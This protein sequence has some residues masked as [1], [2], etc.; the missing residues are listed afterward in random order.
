MYPRSASVFGGSATATTK[1]TD[2]VTSLEMHFKELA[3]LVALGIEAIAVAVV[4]FGALQSLLRLVASAWH[5]GAEPRV[6][7]EIWLGFAAWIVL[8][9]E[10]ALAADIVRTAIAPTW[11]DIG[12]LAAIAA[13]RTGLNYY[14]EK[15]IGAVARKAESINEVRAPAG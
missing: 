14:L 3:G 4:A 5:L 11:Q 6:A 1:R 12:Q 2:N 13:I 15:D 10:F 7:K 8:S 9:L